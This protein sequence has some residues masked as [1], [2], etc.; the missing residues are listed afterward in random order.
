MNI[1]I[2]GDGEMG[3]H[4]AKLLSKED[5]DITLI[6]PN[7]DFLEAVSN[8]ADILTLEGDAVKLSILQKAKVEK[9]DLFI[10]V[11]H[12]ENPN[13]VACI[14]A[15]KLGAKRCIARV[16]NIENLEPANKKIF[17]DL[18]IDNLVSPEGI[19][20]IEI[21]KLINQTAADEIF[22][23]SEGKLSLFSIKLDERALVI[24][25]SLQEIVKERGEMGF[26]AVA[27]V[28]K[29]ETIIPNGNTR[30]QLGDLA[31]MITKPKGIE[32]IL[33]MGGRSKQKMNNVMLVGGGRIGTNVALNLEDKVTLKLVEI[34][35]ERCFLLSDKL[36]NTLIIN[37]DIRD[38]KL[39]EDENISSMDAFISVTRD[40]ETN[41]LTCLLAKKYGVKKTIALIENIDFIDVAHNVGIDTIINKKLIASSYIERFALGVGVES[42]KLLSG[43]DA[44]VLEL[45]V[46][47]GS[48]ITKKIIADLDL[49]ENAIIG[50]LI[51]N[52]VAMI[53]RGS[54]KI[55]AGDK[56]IV[57]SLPS[58]VRNV[59]KLF[60]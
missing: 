36:H 7:S 16:S 50:G 25:K 49:P 58:C 9:A 38:L 42:I 3:S 48:Y 14:L 28:R 10:S 21:V 47:E 18:G 33:E 8:D 52:N 1:I 20:A 51:R 54:T 44:E 41:I 4:L 23:F 46:A 30:F 39:L 19:A 12:I 13:V 60:N 2:A 45:I 26:R 5:H 6:N 35:K 37:G 53:T 32:N 57:F 40:S 55:E 59:S 31:Y 15:K 43:V 34:D 56:V 22:E 17:N 11:M 24:N 27:V 29:G